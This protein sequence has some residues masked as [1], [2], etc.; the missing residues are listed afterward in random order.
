MLK[1]LGISSYLWPARL[2]KAPLHCKVFGW[3]LF[4][5]LEMWE[6]SL[7]VHHHHPLFPPVVKGGAILQPSVPFVGGQGSGGPG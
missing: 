6:E 2:I 4:S 7:R 3:A 5:R 1:D